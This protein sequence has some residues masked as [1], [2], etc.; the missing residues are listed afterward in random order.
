MSVSHCLSRILSPMLAGF[1]FACSDPTGHAPAAVF[2]LRSIGGE[3]IPA[4]IVLGGHSYTALADTLYIASPSAQ[5]RGVLRRAVAA[6]YQPYSPRLVRGD[7]DF[8]WHGAVLSVFFA[9]QIRQACLA[10]FS[11][12]TGKF[13]NRTLLFPAYGPFAPE[14]RYERIR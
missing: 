4:T 13:S 3:T 10:I 6:A 9:C 2:V 11:Y 5:G 1:L 14:R 12:E 8:I 7:H